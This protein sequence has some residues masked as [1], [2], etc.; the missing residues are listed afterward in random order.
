MKAEILIALM[1]AIIGVHTLWRAI[2]AYR[3]GILVVRRWGVRTTSL[4]EEDSMGF[5][6]NL[7]MQT[8]AG[9]AFLLTATLVVLLE[10]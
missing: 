4:R 9:V 2:R 1:I 5:N 3:S 6:A 10:I 7:A 8:F